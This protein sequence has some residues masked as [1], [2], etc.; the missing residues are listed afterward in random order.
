[1]SNNTKLPLLNSLIANTLN[2]RNPFEHVVD[3]SGGYNT[4]FLSIAYALNNFQSK[5][6]NSVQY[7]FAKQGN[8]AVVAQ[9]SGNSLV[10]TNL[11]VTLVDPNFNDYRKGDKVMDS[12]NVKARVLSSSPGTVTLEPYGTILVAATHFTAAMFCKVIGDASPN[13]SSRGKESL[14]NVPTMDFNLS[15]YKRDSVYIDLEDMTDTYVKY[16]GEMW[17][18]AQ[19][20]TML[21]RFARN[22]E[23]DFIESDRG[24]FSTSD[25]D[26]NSNGG[27]NWSIINRNGTY[28]PSSNIITQSLLNEMLS[29]ISKKRSASKKEVTLLAGEDA[30][31][32]IHTFINDIGKFAGTANTF[33]GTEVRGLQYNKYA[34]GSI[35]LNIV[36]F[37]YFN[38]PE[39]FPEA[40]TIPGAQGTKASNSFYLI[41][42]T[43]IPYVDGGNTPAIEMFHFGKEMYYGHIKGMASAGADVNDYMNP[44]D[45]IISSDVSGISAHAMARNGINIVDAK[46]MGFFKVIA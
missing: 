33:G 44:A 15:S 41:D 45:T 27:L 7:E 19:E 17:S 14:Y 18:F 9:I 4:P 42:T 46:G 22:M 40:T 11:V 16:D 43:P 38:N 1:M 12:N 20:M 37:P 31:Q 3:I 34:I 39:F 8:L 13:R 30:M 32:T 29:S 5:Q 28:V 10:G 23:Q 2:A 26:S 6:V 24:V 21:Q 25:G 35:S 36:P